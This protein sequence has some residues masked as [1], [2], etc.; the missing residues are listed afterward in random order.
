MQRRIFAT[1][2]QASKTFGAEQAKTLFG[3]S[4]GKNPSPQLLQKCA[5]DAGQMPTKAG[6]K[7]AHSENTN[8]TAFHLCFLSHKTGPRRVHAFNLIDMLL[9]DELTAFSRPS[10]PVDSVKQLLSL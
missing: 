2:R 4:L 10:R 6:L 8:E 3:R 9:Q 5:T 7:L 1:G